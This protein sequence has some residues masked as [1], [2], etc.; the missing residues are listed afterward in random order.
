MIRYISSKYEFKAQT[1]TDTYKIVVKGR[2]DAY[3]V[4][5]KDGNKISTGKEGQ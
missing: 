5:Y 1:N 4:K 2:K 3:I